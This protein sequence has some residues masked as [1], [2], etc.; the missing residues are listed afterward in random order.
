M[1][2]GGKIF[3][4]LGK[5]VT[6]LQTGSFDKCFEVVLVHE[7]GFSQDEGDPGGATKYGVAINED[8]AALTK[9]LGHAPTVDDIK[10]LTVAQAGQIFRDNYWNPMQLD[11]VNDWRPQLVLFDM[12]VLIGLGGST[13]YAQNATGSD[14]DG[15]IGPNTLGAINRM[16]PVDFCR[17]F[18]DQCQAHFNGLGQGGMHWALAGWTNRVNDLRSRVSV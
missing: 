16:N 12:C 3:P 13:R 18:L 8:S 7:G 9:I 4:S 6:P 11:S 10:N 17:A 15:V 14:V 1:T 5:T 2:G